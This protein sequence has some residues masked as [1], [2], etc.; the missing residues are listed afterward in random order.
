MDSGHMYRNLYDFKLTPFS[1]GKVVV[2]CET[3][4]DRLAVVGPSESLLR[5]LRLMIKGHLHSI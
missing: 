3:R 5:P 1:E 4:R 2:L